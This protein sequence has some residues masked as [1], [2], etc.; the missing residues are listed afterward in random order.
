[1]IL[2]SNGTFID[3]QTLEFRQADLL[4][5]PGAAGVLTF[6]DPVQ[7]AIPASRIDRTIDCTGR[8]ITRSFANGHHHVYSALAR[9]MPTP[10]KDPVNFQEILRY[11]WWTLDKALDPAMIR[12]SALVTA[13]ACAKRGVTFVVDHHAS[14][15]AVGGSLEIIARAFDTVG[16]SHLPR[17]SRKPRPI[18]ISDRDWW[19]CTHHLP[20]ETKP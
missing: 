6:H 1:M 14:P 11:V 2:L 7:T 18:L 16:L 10:K 20:W 12:A 8:F 15:F 19:D 4:V 5:E 9:G 17:V 13:I 3:W